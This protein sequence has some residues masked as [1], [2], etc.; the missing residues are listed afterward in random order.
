ML[1]KSS[2]PLAGPGQVSW[3]I[4]GPQL[5]HK[6]G[7]AR[8]CEPTWSSYIERRSEEESRLSITVRVVDTTPRS[9]Q[10]IASVCATFLCGVEKWRLPIAILLLRLHPSL[11]QQSNTV[12]T[13]RMRGTGRCVEKRRLLVDIS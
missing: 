2:P 10:Q 6:T 13:S 1:L 4:A 9:D 11:Q 12:E 3:E 8:A 5:G 7:W